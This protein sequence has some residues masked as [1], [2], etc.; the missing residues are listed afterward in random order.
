MQWGSVDFEL[1]LIIYGQVIIRY[2]PSLYCFE[3]LSNLLVCC[4]RSEGRR[5][6]RCSPHAPK[7]IF[8][9]CVS[10]PFICRHRQF[11]R[12]PTTPF[13]RTRPLL[14]YSNYSAMAKFM[15]LLVA[16]LATVRAYVSIVLKTFSLFL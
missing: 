4:V 9:C 15:V 2:V 14:V 5:D 16:C 11:R 10:R 3:A 8:L 7:Q 13:A 12:I 1:L 6:K